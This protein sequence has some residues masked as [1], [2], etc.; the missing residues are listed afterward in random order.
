MSTIEIIIAICV[1]AV[2]GAIA[3]LIA[4][5]ANWGIEKRK[6]K[7]EWRKGFINECKRIINK[8]DFDVERFIVTYHY[9]NLKVHLSDLL[10]KEIEDKPKKYVSGIRLSLS[11]SLNLVEKESILKNKLLD[12]ITIIEKEWGLL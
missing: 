12:E 4:P 11:E 10:K 1:S 8:R 3:S 2:T 9:S 7:F 6:K 5:W